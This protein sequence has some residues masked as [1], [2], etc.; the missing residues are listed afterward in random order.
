M[1]KTLLIAAALGTALAMQAQTYVETNDLDQF[2]VIP[3]SLTVDGQ[4]R[5]VFHNYDIHV[6]TVKNGNLQTETTMSY[7]IDTVDVE[8]EGTMR[9]YEV[10]APS[11]G[12]FNLHDGF[13]EHE[14]APTFTQSLFNTTVDYE[15]LWPVLSGTRT[16]RWGHVV[17]NCQQVVAK[18][19]NGSVVSTIQAPD[20]YFFDA[21]S[22][23]YEEESAGRLYIEYCLVVEIGNNTYLVLGI[24]DDDSDNYDEKLAAWYR[25]DRQTQSISL[26]EVAPMSVR[27][28]VAGRGQEIVVE[29][30]DEAQAHELQVVD[31]QGRTVKRVPVQPGQRE[32]RIGTADL[33]RGVNFINARNH[34]A[35][36]IIVK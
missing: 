11:F 33:G 14:G 3:A 24:T 8:C 23:Y 18:S 20:G 2:S 16:D 29:L 1:K 17:P 36:K 6:V 9:R 27:P 26:A 12:Y 31:A 35:A 4:P 13:L 15:Y 10:S 7:P 28:S 30:G 19:T 25:I 21:H 22:S 32:V 34:G 5:L